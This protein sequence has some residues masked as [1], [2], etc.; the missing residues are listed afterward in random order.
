MLRYNTFKSSCAPLPHV[1][2]LCPVTTRSRSPASCFSTF[3]AFTNLPAKVAQTACMSACQHIARAL[4]AVL[5]G[6]E[7]KQLSLG[8]LQQLNLDVIQCERELG[9]N[10]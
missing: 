4:L 9:N 2:D 5:L 7:V 1:H 8:A 6:E 3:T 10:L